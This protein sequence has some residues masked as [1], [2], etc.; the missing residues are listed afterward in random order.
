MSNGTPNSRLPERIGRLDELAKNLWWSWHPQ[1][2]DL[3][4]A[5]DYPLWRMSGHNPV[6][7]L[8]EVSPDK[9]QA[10]ATDP[11]FLALYDFVMSTFDVDMSAGDTWFAAK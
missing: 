11:A 10:A 7:Q 3:F 1:A 5:L 4:R 8:R 2:R 9:L 6:K